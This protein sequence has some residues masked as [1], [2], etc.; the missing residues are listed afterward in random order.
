MGWYQRRVHGALFLSETVMAEATGQTYPAQC[1]SV[2][3]GHYIVIKDRPCKVIDTSTSKTGKHGHAK[4]NMTAL[5]I[6]TNKKLEDSHPSTHNVVVP[7]VV[8]SEYMVLNITDD[9]FLSLLLDNGQTKDDLR[10]PDNEDGQK[11][12]EM[13]DDGKEVIVSVLA[14]M[15]IEEVKGCKEGN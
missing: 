15:G 12:R 9:G 11:I 1:S 2:K 4:V 14:A 10:C 7:V 3:K 5:D 8:R 13:F 6:F